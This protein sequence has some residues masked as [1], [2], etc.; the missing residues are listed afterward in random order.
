MDKARSHHRPVMVEEV[1]SG[2]QAH[3]E[4]LYVDCTVG[5]G[6]HSLAIVEST[7]SKS[8]LICIDADPEAIK[9][10]QRRLFKHSARVILVNSNF[11]HL[12]ETVLAHHG[13][14]AQGILLDLGLSSLQ[15]DGE[16]RGFSFQ[17]DSPLDMRF[18]PKQ[19]LTAAQIVNSYTESELVT[20][21]YRLGEEPQ[22]KRISRALIQSRPLLTTRHLVSVIEAVVPRRGKRLHPATKVFQA[23]RMT[24]NGE[25]E[26][27]S[28]VL[29]QAIETLANK[30]R[31]VVISYH[32]LEDRIVKRF[33]QRESKDCLCPLEILI[34]QCKHQAKIR[35]LTK[36]VIAPSK[37]EVRENPRSRSARLR[38]AERI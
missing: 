10:A 20:L 33:L 19:N 25:L 24:V 16:L 5:E 13:H 27:L 18:D 21:L 6:G 37:Q 26:N 4:G 34:C 9:A 3:D 35:I 30:G 29:Q 14:Q 8:R 7:D 17:T 2:L 11:S 31:L 36:R 38:I 23:L 22:A 12:A 1:L 15:L 32:S 28:I